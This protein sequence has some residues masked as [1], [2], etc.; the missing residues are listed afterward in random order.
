[1]DPSESYLPPAALSTLKEALTILEDLVNE[2]LDA[3]NEKES[4]GMDGNEF[5]IYWILKSEDID[6]GNSL[7]KEISPS[8]A[9][10]QHWRISEVHERELRKDLYAAPINL[11]LMDKKK[12]IDKLLN[13]LGEVLDDKR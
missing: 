12:L 8:F 1:M 7:A 6:D 10:Y 11:P 2:R 4:S 9:N 13:S 3:K 5:S